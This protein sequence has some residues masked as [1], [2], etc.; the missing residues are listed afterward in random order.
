MRLLNKEF[1][2][3]LTNQYLTENVALF[4]YSLI[5]TTR[6]NKIIEVGYGYTSAFLIE[7]IQDVQDENLEY[8]K[9]FLVNDLKYSPELVIVDNDAQSNDLNL[10]ASLKQNKSI[11]L[12]DQDFYKYWESCNDFFDLIWIDFE[13]GSDYMDILFKVY[14]QLTQ[15]GFVIFHNTV[16][17]AEGKVFLA[18]LDLY[19][20]KD[21]SFEVMTFV[22]P[23]KMNQSSYTVIKKKTHY[24]TY[25]L[26]S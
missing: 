1:T 17:N 10:I 8:M 2:K 12:I 14:P 15:G 26:W 23:H 19:R 20:M 21:D 13:G 3:N 9:D 18:N 6:P 16:H 22:E 7:A 24:P 5:R 25:R 4:L 11:N